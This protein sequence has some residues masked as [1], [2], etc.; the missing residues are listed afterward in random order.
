MNRLFIL[1]KLLLLLIPLALPALAQHKL[2]QAWITPDLPTPESVLYVLDDE[3][4]LFVALIDGQ[5]DAVDG[6]GGIA[7]FN[8][9]S[10]TYK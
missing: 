3:P 2:E 7:K 8:I 6:K 9:Q 4:Y 5:G 1:P 10:I